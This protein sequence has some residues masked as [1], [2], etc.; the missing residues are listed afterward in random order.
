MRLVGIFGT[1]DGGGAAFSRHGMG[2]HGVNLGQQRYALGSALLLGLLSSPDS[3]AQ[4]CA[5]PTYNDDIEIS[6][7]HVN[8]FHSSGQKAT[9]A[10]LSDA[11]F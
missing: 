6:L 7:L 9:G 10:A 3:S 4:A 5:T 8:P 11:L 2:A 1:G